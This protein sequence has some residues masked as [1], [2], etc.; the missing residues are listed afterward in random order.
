MPRT[1][2][3]YLIDTLLTALFAALAFTGILLEYFV[4]RGPQ[5]GWYAL[6]GMNHDGWAALHASLALAFGTLVLVHLALHW[7]WVV[8]MSR[9]RSP[10]SVV[11]WL[12]LVMIGAAATVGIG[13]LVA[14]LARGHGRRGTQMAPAGTRRQEQRQPWRGRRGE[15]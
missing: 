6:W 12:M 9:R 3:H 4:S 2:L 5:A 11:A 10:R 7:D 13:L 8:G 1:A 15:S 14:T